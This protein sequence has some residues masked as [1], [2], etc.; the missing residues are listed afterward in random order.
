LFSSLSDA[1][2]STDF[3]YQLHKGFME[4]QAFGGE[5]IYDILGGLI[6]C[7]TKLGLRFDMVY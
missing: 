3:I 5:R 4:T 6:A 1:A 7:N 2:S